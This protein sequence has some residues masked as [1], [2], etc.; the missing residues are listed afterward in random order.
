[1]ETN[2]SNN[3]N[4]NNN[5]NKKSENNEN[6]ENITDIGN[7]LY[8]FST[9]AFETH[10]RGPLWFIVLGLCIITGVIIGIF[11]EALSV[12]LLSVMIGF[13]YTI[14]Y[15]Q[16]ADEV[17]V[18]FTDIGMLWKQHFFSYQEI[19]KFWILYIP[20]QQKTLYVYIKNGKS[21]KEI[22]IPIQSQ[23]IS[24]IRDTLGYYVPEDEESHESITNIISRKLKL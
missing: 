17:T 19:E 16:K 7:I 15:N 14:T 1:M 6:S 5:N 8:K 22:T 11:T 18:V 24:K 10:E 3:N 9:P 13:I 2:N 21:K 12:V 20:H 4:K 23:K